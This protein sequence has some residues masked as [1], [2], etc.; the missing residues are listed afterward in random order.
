MEAAE[1]VNH[2]R[3]KQV[4]CEITCLEIKVSSTDSMKL[5]IFK[6]MKNDKNDKKKLEEQEEMM[7]N[8]Y[9]HSGEHKDHEY[10]DFRQRSEASKHL[11]LNSIGS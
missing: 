9:A 10:D 2:E 1:Y 8:D 3:K 5:L 11:N 7:M 4:Q 6:F